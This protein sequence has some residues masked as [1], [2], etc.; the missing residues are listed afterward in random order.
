MRWVIG[1][2]EHNDGPVSSLLPKPVLDETKDGKFGGQGGA[3]TFVL[4]RRES[5]S[6]REVENRG[7]VDV[8]VSGVGRGVAIPKVTV[9]LIAEAAA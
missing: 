4:C 7:G 1:E 5:E 2:C 6:D 3:R 9:S 8:E